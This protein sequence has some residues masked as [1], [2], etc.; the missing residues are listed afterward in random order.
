[1]G[2]DVLVAPYRHPLLVAATMGRRLAG[3]RRH[4]VWASATREFEVLG[5]APY[6]R[7]GEVTEEFLRARRSA[8]GYSVVS[9][10]TPVPVWVGGNA[11]RAQRRA[12]LLGY[13]WHPLWMPDDV[14]A[15][16]RRKILEAWARAN[17]VGPF[18]FS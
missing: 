12:A 2:T 18:T 14:H 7:R 17:L 13:G 3:N 16:A 9:S 6:A 10:L 1:M 4:L 8:E 15:E 5:A 11:A